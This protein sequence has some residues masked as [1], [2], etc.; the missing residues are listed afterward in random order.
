MNDT[1]GPNSSDSSK[2]ADPQSSSESKSPRKTQSRG[3]MGKT[4]VC[5]N[6]TTEKPCSEF[7]VNSKGHLRQNCVDCTKQIARAYKQARPEETKDS[8]SAWRK[9]RRG[10]A[11]VNTA[12]HRAKARGLEFDLDPHEIQRVIVNGYCELTGI[13]FSLDEPRAWNAPSLDRIDPAQGYTR[14]NTRVVLYALNV[15]ANTWGPQKIIEISSA[16]LK[17][18]QIASQNL[19]FWLADRL[20]ARINES[21]NPLF[22]LTWKVTVTPSGRQ[23]P[24]L[25]ATAR[26]TSVS[27]STGWA[28]PTERDYRFPNSLPR[29]ERHGKPDDQLNN[30]AKHLAPQGAMILQSMQKAWPTSRAEDGESSGMRHSRG[31]TDTLTAVSTLAGW[32]SPKAAEAGPDYAI[33]NRPDSGGI[34]LQTAAAL[35]AWTSPTVPKGGMVVTEE[36]LLTMKKTDGSKAQIH[37]DNQVRLA[38]W[39]SPTATDARGSDYTYANG[40]PETPSLKLPGQAKLSQEPSGSTSSD[41]STSIALPRSTVA[42]TSTGPSSSGQLNPRHASWLMGLPPIWDLCFM[43]LKAREQAAKARAKELKAIEKQA[44]QL[45]K[46]LKQSPG[47]S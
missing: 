7:Y 32:P 34:S 40:N 38:S 12:K 20:K 42:T 29:L 6:C 45:A 47:R 26:G 30:Q 35:A 43:R 41:P 39:V 4:K 28:S 46:S 44:R 13:A 37:L 10:F 33:L 15:M 23:I 22:N 14:A 9:Q 16:I 11:L 17:Q 21:S 1:F 3:S 8:F 18:R 27:D 2:R 31:V 19:S 25:V 24:R 5:K 36:E